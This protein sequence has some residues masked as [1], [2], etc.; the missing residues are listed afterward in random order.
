MTLDLQRLLE[1]LDIH[2]VQ[3]VVIG[4]VAAIAHGSATLTF[5]LDLCYARDEVNLEQLARA[6]APF[7]PRLRGVADDVPFKFDG[8]T[9]RNGL[10]FTLSTDAG[11]LDLLGEVSGVGTYREVLANSDEIEIYQRKCQVLKLDA[12]IRAKKATGRPKDL[13][14]LPELEALLALRNRKS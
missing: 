12:L 14:A 2:R 7:R 5:D 4:G 3:Y 11:D 1:S 13:N 6:L 8:S 9:L 10:N